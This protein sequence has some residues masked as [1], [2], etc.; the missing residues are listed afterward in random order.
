M[1]Y[2]LRLIFEG[3]LQYDCVSLLIHYCKL[4]SLVN[5]VT[6]VTAMYVTVVTSYSAR[7]VTVVTAVSGRFVTL[8]TRLV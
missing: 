8:F 4:A 5:V 2:I 6:S 3:R 1:K 7:V